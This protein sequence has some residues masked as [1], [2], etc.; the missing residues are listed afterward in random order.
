MAELSGD[1]GGALCGRRALRCWVPA[2]SPAV[3]LGWAAQPVC[4]SPCLAGPAKRCLSSYPILLP[5]CRQGWREGRASPLP[6]D[7]E[8]G[9]ADLS[10]SGAD[11]SPSRA[12]DAWGIQQSTA[13]ASPPGRGCRRGA[14]PGRGCSPSAFEP[15][16]FSPVPLASACV[17]L[18]AA[19]WRLCP[20]APRPCPCW[21]P[22]ASPL[23]RE[24]WAD[25]W[26]LP[27]P[28]PGALSWRP[29]CRGGTHLAIWAGVRSGQSHCRVWIFLGWQLPCPAFVQAVA[30]RQSLP[31]SSPPTPKKKATRA[32][33][34]PAASPRPCRQQ[35]PP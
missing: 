33:V 30:C 12:G 8:T 23:G 34:C 17:R 20:P 18:G 25:S 19:W 31:L 32:S 14:S 13:K 16:V 28:S 9:A 35:L 11:V 10:P 15:S 22:P 24:G 7:C 21:N 29:L 6:G 2:S 1:H 4:S 26:E 3:T 27:S 5:V